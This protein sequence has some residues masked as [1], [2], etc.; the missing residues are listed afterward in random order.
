MKVTRETYSGGKEGAEVAL[1]VIEEVSHTW[2]GQEPPEGFIGKSATN[3][4]ANDEMWEFFQ[5]QSRK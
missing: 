1:I 5:Q 2:P 4:T 3:V